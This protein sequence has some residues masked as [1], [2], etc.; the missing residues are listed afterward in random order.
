MRVLSVGDCV[1]NG[2]FRLHSRFERAVNFAGTRGVVSVVAPEVG[3]GPVNL[4]VDAIDPG[5]AAGLTVTGSGA[6]GRSVVFD[7]RPLDT[8]GATAHES[9]IRLPR[10]SSRTLAAN[11]TTLSAFLTRCA[12][13][14]SLA[15]LLDPRRSS[16]FRPGFERA[17]A[18]HLRDC[19]TDAMHGDVIRAAHRMA[20][21]GFGLTPSGDDFVCGVLVAMRVGE[22]ADDVSLWPLRREIG[23]A[24]RTGN[25]LTDAFLSHACAGRVSATTQALLHALVAGAG[26]DVAGAARE[27]VSTG[28]T[29]GADFAVGLLLQLRTYLPQSIARRARVL[30]VPP[31]GDTVCH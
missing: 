19:A 10:W 15:F 3:G 21:C 20:G 11:L 26:D 29:S 14:K 24:A 5:P 30:G 31:C 8:E 28:E 25:V 23:E 1:P 27:V 13:E 18:A 12:P 6:R 9:C 4:V 7:G 17:V 2:T 16:E 22:T